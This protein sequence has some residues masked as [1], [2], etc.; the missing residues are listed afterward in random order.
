M[1]KKKASPSLPATA[2]WHNEQY[3]SNPTQVV[4]GNSYKIRSTVCFIPTLGEL[5]VRTVQAFN[6]LMKPMNQKFTQVY[7]VNHEVGKAYE[8]MVDILRTNEELRSWKYVLTME[9]DNLPPPDGL[10]KL[11]DDIESGKWDAVGGLYWLKGE[12]GKPMSYGRPRDDNGIPILP[13]D[14]V[15]W[16]PPP[17]TVAEVNGLGMGF[18][19]FKMKMF[20]DER[21]VRPL[22]MTEQSYTPGVGVRAFTQDLRFFEAAKKLDYRFAVSTRVLVG[23]YDKVA[24]KVW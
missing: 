3:V 24:D 5:P 13:M 4:A 11:Y 21:F 20:L 9:H 16:L 2:G 22:F 14:F 10:L 19:L 7:L 15:P 18:T 1:K 8:Q 6:N 17:N 23:H 12:G